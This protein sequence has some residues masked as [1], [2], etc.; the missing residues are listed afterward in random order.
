MIPRRPAARPG[1]QAIARGLDAS[2]SSRIGVRSRT[3]PS[4]PS[5]GGASRGWA[6]R[7]V[8]PSS[9]V[10]AI[11]AWRPDL[12][13]LLAGP[14]GGRNGGVDRGPYPPGRTVAPFLVHP[15]GLAPCSHGR[16]ASDRAASSAIG[17]VGPRR[18]R[19]PRRAAGGRSS[20]SGPGRPGSCSLR[21]S[22]S[23]K[24]GTRST[25]GEDESPAVAPPGD[26]DPSFAL[27]RRPRPTGLGIPRGGIRL[28][29]GRLL[30]DTEPGG[31]DDATA[32]PPC[33]RFHRGNPQVCSGRNASSRS[34]CS[35]RCPL[36]SARAVVL[37]GHR[38]SSSR[39]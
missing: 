22:R 23:R 31:E 33:D 2:S 17:F 13:R 14:L 15:L 29:R 37:P 8:V 19:W 20:P 35:A 1:D 5:S 10:D 26:C 3:R 21:A 32:G 24:V 7:R 28:I 27:R 38:T 11:A 12:G 16:S 4:H 30:A 36:R 9:E 6:S 25:A 18:V 34:Y 39:K